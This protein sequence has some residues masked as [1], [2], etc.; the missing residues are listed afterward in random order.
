M[1]NPFKNILP[2]DFLETPHPGDNKTHSLQES[3]YFDAPVSPRSGA[4]PLFSP[5]IAMAAME[6]GVARSC[7]LGRVDGA[8][9]QE[10]GRA[11]V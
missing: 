6:G 9:M 8:R 1:K 4:T 2:P 11:H 3:R 7:G 10:I 5:E